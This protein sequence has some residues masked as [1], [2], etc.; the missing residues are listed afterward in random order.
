MSCPEGA[1]G[2]SRQGRG[3]LVMPIDSVDVLWSFVEAPLLGVGLKSC[4][5]GRSKPLLVFTFDTSDRV[6]L[7]VE[8]SRAQECE[9]KRMGEVTNS[10]TGAT[11]PPAVRFFLRGG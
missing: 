1:L 2:S 3:Q 4:Y 10:F 8:L 11:A 6:V 9:E 7:L 5:W